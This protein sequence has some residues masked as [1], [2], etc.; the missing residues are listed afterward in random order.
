MRQ[1]AKNLNEGFYIPLTNSLINKRVEYYLDGKKHSA[2]LKSINEH[3]LKLDSELI[4]RQFIV[5]LYLMPYLITDK[6][7]VG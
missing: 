3:Y 5:E 4:S 1:T 7:L 6:I 2:I